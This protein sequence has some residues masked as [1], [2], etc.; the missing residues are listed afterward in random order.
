MMMQGTT[1]IEV[2]LGWLFPGAVNGGHR[3]EAM[4]Q[5]DV[6]GGESR[7][8]MLPDLDLSRSYKQML[9]SVRNVVMH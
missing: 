6:G 9:A 8:V 4:H 1:P 3:K 5:D 2:A 7:Y